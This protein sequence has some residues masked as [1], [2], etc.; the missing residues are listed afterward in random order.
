MDELL[1]KLSNFAQTP[2]S[3]RPML[4]VRS[5]TIAPAACRRH[6][7][8]VSPRFR[9]GARTRKEFHWHRRTTMAAKG[10]G[11]SSQSS[12]WLGILVVFDD[13]LGGKN[14]E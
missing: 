11:I 3:E 2:P 7:H 8:S 14:N 9:Q 5:L 4:S 6:P 13:Q 12:S 10:R 1:K